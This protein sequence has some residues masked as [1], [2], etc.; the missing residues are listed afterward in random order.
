MVQNSKTGDIKSHC[1][2]LLCVSVPRSHKQEAA[3]VEWKERGN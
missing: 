3:L 2:L 1:A